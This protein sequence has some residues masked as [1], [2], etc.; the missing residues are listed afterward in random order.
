M[1]ATQAL[2][3]QRLQT[4]FVDVKNMGYPASQNQGSLKISPVQASDQID[5]K[6]QDQQNKIEKTDKTD[7]A[8]SDV[9]TD[10]KNKVSQMQDIGVE[11]TRHKASG[12]MMVRVVEKGSNTLIR[13]IPSEEFLDMVAKMDQM[14][15]I[16]FDKKV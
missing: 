4:G 11:F 3:V 6:N 5:L 16:L 1:E 8:L 12:R 14:I 10:F 15:G 9:L 2:K 13:E 7:K